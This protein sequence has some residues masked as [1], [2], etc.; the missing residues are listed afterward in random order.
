MAWF[1]EGYGPAELN[2][3][4]LSY[5]RYERIV[6]DIA[7]DAEQIFGL[8]GSIEERQ[9]R[10]DLVNQFLPNNV[11]EIAHRTYQQLVE[12]GT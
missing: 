3:A 5:Y 4:A 7:E 6:V 9:K 1:Y 11:V 12:A 8:H 2:L 10:L